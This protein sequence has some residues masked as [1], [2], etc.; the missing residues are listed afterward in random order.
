VEKME[1][2]KKLHE[3]AKKSDWLKK[4]GAYD[5]VKD[6]ETELVKDFT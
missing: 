2:M 3:D 6:D 5:M 4:C 1:A